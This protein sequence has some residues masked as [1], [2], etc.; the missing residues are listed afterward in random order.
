MLLAS[1][2][3]FLNENKITSTAKAE[4]KHFFILLKDLHKLKSPTLTPLVQCLTKSKEEEQEEQVEEEGE[5][6]EKEEEEVEHEDE[7]E[8]EEEEEQ[9]EQEK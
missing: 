7:Q 1:Q 8:E 9:V 5:E 2:L 6:E 3:N 4:T